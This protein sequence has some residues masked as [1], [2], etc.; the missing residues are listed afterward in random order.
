MG[1]SSQYFLYKTDILINSS[2]KIDK[3]VRGHHEN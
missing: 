1:A 3:N 2:D